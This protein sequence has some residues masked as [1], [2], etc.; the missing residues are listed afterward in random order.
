MD[1][2]IL[3]NDCGR[4]IHALIACPTAAPDDMMYGGPPLSKSYNMIVAALNAPSEV[5]PW[6]IWRA[7]LAL[8]PLS[9][10]H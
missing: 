8:A 3:Y 2:S 4:S 1:A 5:P 6:L 10:F 9:S 7:F